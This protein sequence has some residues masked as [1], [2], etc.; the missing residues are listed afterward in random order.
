ME[1]NRLLEGRR[2][3]ATVPAGQGRG[4]AANGL[5]WQPTKHAAWSRSGGAVCVAGGIRSDIAEPLRRPR[6]RWEKARQQ[7]TARVRR[8][9]H[10]KVGRVGVAASGVRY[11]ARRGPTGEARGYEASLSRSE[12]S[13]YSRELLDKIAG[14]SS[15]DVRDGRGR[16]KGQ[17]GTAGDQGWRT[18]STAG[19]A[20]EA[21]GRAHSGDQA[22]A[23]AIESRIDAIDRELARCGK[24]GENT[25]V[26][27]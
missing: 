9:A 18:G 13:A 19:V 4:S 20:L 27:S 25:P 23:Q 1:A 7:A 11:R 12:F 8:S 3:A 15:G 21:Y 6:E 22:A 14:C 2:L 24:D 17:A 10:G 5:C 26:V 16:D